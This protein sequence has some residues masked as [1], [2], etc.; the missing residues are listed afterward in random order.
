MKKVLTMT[1]IAIIGMA[2]YGC[3]KTEKINENARRYIFLFKPDL[4][5]KSVPNHYKNQLTKFARFGFQIQPITT[6]VWRS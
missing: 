3:T 5:A 2:A 6:A 4:D 1:I